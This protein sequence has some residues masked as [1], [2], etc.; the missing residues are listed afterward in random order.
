MCN[1][2]QMCQ[3]RREQGSPFASLPDPVERR[4]N[5]SD[6]QPP[7]TFEAVR[8]LMRRLCPLSLASISLCHSYLYSGRGARA[9]TENLENGTSSSTTKTAANAPS[10][11]PCALAPWCHTPPWRENQAK[12]ARSW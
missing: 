11:R 1:A 3:R 6:S 7:M 4:L 5:C 8:L 2:A 9:P 12:P 10:E